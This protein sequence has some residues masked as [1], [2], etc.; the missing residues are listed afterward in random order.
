MSKL[1]TL[2]SLATLLNALNTIA[3]SVKATKLTFALRLEPLKEKE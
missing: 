3:S 2:L 1:E